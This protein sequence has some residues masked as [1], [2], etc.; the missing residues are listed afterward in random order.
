MPPVLNTL[1]PGLVVASASQS[2]P[3]Q[4]LYPLLPP[5]LPPALDTLATG[6]SVAWGTL[7]PPER[8]QWRWQAALEWMPTRTARLPRGRS[9]PERRGQ[10]GLHRIGSRSRTTPAS[11]GPPTINQFS[12][13]CG[14]G[15]STAKYQSRYQSGRGSAA[16]M[17]GSGGLPSS[18]GPNTRT[19]NLC[20]AGI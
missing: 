13:P 6:L 12:M 1:A 5:L 10:A 20:P 2:A 8:F 14:S 11:S 3:K 9:I 16:M 19:N 18:G 15:A 7:A 4:V 17:L